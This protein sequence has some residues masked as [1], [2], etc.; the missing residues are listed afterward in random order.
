M[1]EK[2][3]SVSILR[4]FEKVY[5]CKSFYSAAKILNLNHSTISRHLASLEKCVGQRLFEKKD[6]VL[7][8]TE[9]GNK[10]YK[11]VV[12]AFNEIEKTIELINTNGK[13]EIRLLAPAFFTHQ[14]LINY[15]E[16]IRVYLEMDS[17]T[18]DCHSTGKENSYDIEILFG[19]KLS[20]DGT[21][22]VEC[23]K[24]CAFVSP[25]YSNT[26]PS[27]AKF[28][29][30]KNEGIDFGVQWHN[31]WLSENKEYNNCKI[32][33]SNDYGWILSAVLKGKGIGFFE[34]NLVYN[35]IKKGR[36]MKLKKTEL[37]TGYFYYIR[38]V[39]GS[40][41]SAIAE[42]IKEKYKEC[43]FESSY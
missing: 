1:K 20:S 6:G 30:Y 40:F 17:I 21:I 8:A 13:N 37:S 38:I 3:P 42:F 41:N 25:H 16:E 31:Y 9:S 5:T 29:I 23:K 15:A 35:H 7:H 26:L 43:M 11:A 12:I 18:I 28:F 33:Y 14:W 24:T 19:D 10:L 2:I 39:N 4:V 36:L 22:L 32:I 27:D 34:E